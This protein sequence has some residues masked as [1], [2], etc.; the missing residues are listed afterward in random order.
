[1]TVVRHPLNAHAWG[2][3][4]SVEDAPA[5]RVCLPHRHICQAHGV[6]LR[7]EFSIYGLRRPEVGRLALVPGLLQRAPVQFLRIGGQISILHLQ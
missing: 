7:D 3:V 2:A 1:M 6:A 4:D 5:L